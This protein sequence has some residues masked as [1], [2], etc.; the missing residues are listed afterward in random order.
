MKAY[1]SNGGIAPLILNFDTTLLNAW[2]RGC[3]ALT[4]QKLL[5]IE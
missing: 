1:G 3:D 4:P 5:L 2:F